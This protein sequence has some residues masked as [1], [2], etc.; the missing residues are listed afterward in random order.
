MLEHREPYAAHTM[1]ARNVCVYIYKFTRLWH[2]AECN[3]V[4]DT[5]VDIREYI[6]I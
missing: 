3:V 6:H 1:F 2:A 5:S 4:I